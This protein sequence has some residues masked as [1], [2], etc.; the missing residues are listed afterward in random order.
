MTSGLR[1]VDPAREAAQ[2]AA[3]GRGRYLVERRL[4]L[5]P[6][7]TVV[8]EEELV[9]SGSLFAVPGTEIPLA[10]AVRY[11]LATA[12]VASSSPADAAPGAEARSPAAPAPEAA[13]PVSPDPAPRRRGGRT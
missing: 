10:I 12:P 3:L 9:G 4:I 2:D 13:P 1:I 8:P 6:E 11:G 5:T 7:G